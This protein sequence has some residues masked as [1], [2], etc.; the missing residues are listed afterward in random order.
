M[1]RIATILLAL[2]LA[3]AGLS[4]ASAQTFDFGPVRSNSGE[5]CLTGYP[6]NN[7]DRLEVLLSPCAPGN[8]LQSWAKPAAGGAIFVLHGGRAFC[9]DVG[10]DEPIGFNNAGRRVFARRC[11]DTP[12]R[13]WSAS[14]DGVFSAA[15]AGGTFTLDAFLSDA[16]RKPGMVQLIGWPQAS[17]GANQRWT[18]PAAPGRARFNFIASGD[19][20]FQNDPGAD[21]ER[22]KREVMSSVTMVSALANVEGYRMKGL[23]IAGD[24]TQNSRN[25]EIARYF[26]SIAGKENQVYDGLG[27]HD[28]VGK[29]WL[30][31][32]PYAANTAALMDKVR[33]PT[34]PGMV[35]YAPAGMPNYSWDWDGVHFVQL[36]L[37]GADGPGVNDWGDDKSAQLD[38]GLTLAFLKQDLAAHKARYG[39]AAPV[40]LVQHYC[41][42]PT[43]P[44]EAK[45]RFCEGGLWWN[46]SQRAAL[47]AAI[48]GTNVIAILTGHWH[49]PNL[50]SYFYYWGGVP[51]FIVGG[52]VEGRSVNVEF[53]YDQ[54]AGGGRMM[55]RPNA[56]FGSPSQC[57]SIAFA[58]GKIVEMNSVCPSKGP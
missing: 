8:A 14:G 32:E 23:V 21:I 4:P 1:H 33:R 57:K 39:A 9:L 30:G 43:P 18:V 38:P 19:P 44:S 56:A 27:N 36:N 51:T 5:G 13:Q 7:P 25:D 11:S 42:T 54:A 16:Q 53:D 49:D 15:T 3:A 34:R 46:K 24:L 55:V 40:V 29:S 31:I 26:Q 2:L 52:M 17:G 41:F 35:N 20:Q 6:A 50:A 48:K 37:M 45:P 12:G 47:A 58:G 22:G 28:L 10:L